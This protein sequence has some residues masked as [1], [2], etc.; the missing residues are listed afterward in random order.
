MKKILMIVSLLVT[1]TNFT[2]GVVYGCTCTV[3]GGSS[4][5]GSTCT[6]QPNGA[7]ICKGACNE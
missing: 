6:P 1:L 2:F 3:R 5:C 7:C 4:C